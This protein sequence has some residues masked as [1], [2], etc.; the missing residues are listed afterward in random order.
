MEIAAKYDASLGKSSNHGGRHKRN[1][2][3]EV[4]NTVAFILARLGDSNDS[5]TDGPLVDD[6]AD[7]SAIGII[8]LRLNNKL[9][10]DDQKKLGPI[11]ESL[12]GV[13]R[14][15]YSA[16]EHESALRKI[17]VS[18]IL[19]VKPDTGRIINNRHL[20]V[21]ESSQW[22]TGRNLKSK[23]SILQM[24]RS[25]IENFQK[26]ERYLHAKSR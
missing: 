2:K 25:A 4:K 22:V 1:D 3:H 13:A 24:D 21:V 26:C 16:D 8:V 11:T 23:V 9:F 6:G 12:N 10:S 15:Q 17:L 18:K 19:T 7:Y 5:C 20:V 14:W